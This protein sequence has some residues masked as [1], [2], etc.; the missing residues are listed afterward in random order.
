[1]VGDL[2]LPSTSPPD[3]LIWD[4]ESDVIAARNF[5]RADA[6]FDDA[7]VGYINASYSGEEVAEAGRLRPIL[8]R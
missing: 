7:R 6:R 1:L 4:A 2:Q 3:P 5:L 8:R